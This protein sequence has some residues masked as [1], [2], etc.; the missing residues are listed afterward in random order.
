MVDSHC[1]LPLVIATFVAMSEGPG[2]V[3]HLQKN[4]WIYVSVAESETTLDGLEP[5]HFEVLKG[6][7]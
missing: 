4:H 6:E 7:R 1:R 2:E 5:F 3:F